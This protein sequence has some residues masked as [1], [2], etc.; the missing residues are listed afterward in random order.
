[1]CR[2]LAVISIKMGCFLV[3]EGINFSLMKRSCGKQLMMSGTRCSMD[4]LIFLR[5]VISGLRNSLTSQ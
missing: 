1:M 5:P 3:L 2:T 4:I